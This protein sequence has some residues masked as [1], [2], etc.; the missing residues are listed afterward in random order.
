[1]YLLGSMVCVKDRTIQVMAVNS[2]GEYR[3]WERAGQVL[4]NSKGRDAGAIPL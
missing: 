1:M 4:V 2:T 3:P